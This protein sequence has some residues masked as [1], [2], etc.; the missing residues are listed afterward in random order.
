[1]LKADIENIS[2]KAFLIIK[3][4]AKC[5]SFCVLQRQSCR[6]YSALIK[7]ELPVFFHKQEMI[8]HRLHG[9]PDYYPS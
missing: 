2:L 8:P 4:H 9:P 6:L 3:P 5:S 7:A 1:M